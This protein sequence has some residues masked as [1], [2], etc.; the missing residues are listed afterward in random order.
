MIPLGGWGWGWVGWCGWFL[1]S[2]RIGLSRSIGTIAQSNKVFIAKIEAELAKEILPSIFALR[3]KF[4]HSIWGEISIK[5]PN[6]HENILV[7]TI[8][9][10]SMKFP[11]YFNNNNK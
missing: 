7:I 3:K 1:L 4:P 6:T 8:S 2:L 5:E 10:L 11:A 9:D